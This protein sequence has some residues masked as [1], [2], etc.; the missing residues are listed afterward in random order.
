MLQ[1]FH[2]KSLQLFCTTAMAFGSL[3]SSKA[4]TKRETRN[5]LQQ[6]EHS[7]GGPVGV[8]TMHAEERPYLNILRMQ[9]DYSR[10]VD[11]KESIK[12]ATLFTPMQEEI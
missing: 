4:P 8:S 9:G 2:Q 1:T 3:N 10:V 5:G 12:G 11:D 6:M 7:W